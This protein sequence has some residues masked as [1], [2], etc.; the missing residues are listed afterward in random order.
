MYNSIKS[1]FLPVFLATL[2]GV[3]L[4]QVTEVVSLEHNTHTGMDNSLVRVSD[5][6][7]V[8]A[9]RGHGND[10][11]ITTFTIPADGSSITEVESLEH[12]KVTG[13][14]NSLV[15]M[16]DDTYALAYKGPQNDGWITTFTISADGS[17]ITEVESL[18]HDNEAGS[19]NSLLRVGDDT[20]ALAY[21]SYH[22]DGFIK[23]FTIPADGSS[24]TEVASL[25]H[26][27][28]NGSD[29]S[30]V[31]VDDDTYAL[32]YR[33]TNN[34]GFITT[35][36]ISADGSSITEVASLNHETTY[37]YEHSLVRVHDET[38]A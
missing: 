13:I 3:A 19:S 16:N 11:W 34:K 7:Y 6:T 26:D 5:D 30:L 32:A 10:G 9:Y 33:S 28:Q 18:E 29:N 15:R 20:Y 37:A 24:I 12:D 25:E 1:R 23:T 22:S 36:T 38:Y 2:S 17:S 21:S 31:R 14:D 27:I 4:S 35:F 8:L